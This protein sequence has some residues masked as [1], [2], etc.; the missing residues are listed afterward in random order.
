MTSVAPGGYGTRTG[1][2]AVL[3][4]CQRTEGWATAA[5][6]FDGDAPCCRH[7]ECISLRQD[8]RRKEGKA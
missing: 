1:L 3:C 4:W 6:V 7:P 2:L 5:M 8:Q